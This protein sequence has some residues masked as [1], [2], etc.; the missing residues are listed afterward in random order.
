[1]RF[2]GASTHKLSIADLWHHQKLGH[3]GEDAYEHQ[4]AA[5]YRDFSSHAADLLARSRSKQAKQRHKK[6]KCRRLRIFL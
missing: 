4:H 2:W 1:M 6:K 3:D 5:H